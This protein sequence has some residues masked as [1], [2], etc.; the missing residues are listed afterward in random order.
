MAPPYP[1]L[2]SGREIRPISIAEQILIRPG[3]QEETI[4]MKT[5]L[6]LVGLLQ[7]LQ[8]TLAS[9]E[10][11]SDSDGFS[12]HRDASSFWKFLESEDTHL[13]HI[14]A[15]WDNI[16]SGFQQQSRLPE[17]LLPESYNKVTSIT[18]LSK[19]ANL[20]QD[21]ASLFRHTYKKKIAWA[22]AHLKLEKKQGAGGK[23][24]SESFQ[25]Q[26]ELIK[27][28]KKSLL[29]VH[30]VNFSYKRAFKAIDKRKKA[31][32]LGSKLKKKI[33]PNSNIGTFELAFNL[34]LLTSLNY[35]VKR[36]D[37]TGNSLDELKFIRKGTDLGTIAQVFSELINEKSVD[38]CIYARIASKLI[39][40]N[41][42]TRLDNGTFSI[43]ARILELAKTYDESL[44]DRTYS[45]ILEKWLKSPG[46]Q[47]RA[48]N[49]IL[50]KS[51]KHFATDLAQIFE[52]RELG[53]LPDM[54]INCFGPMN[55][56]FRVQGM[57]LDRMPCSDDCQT[58][59]QETIN[60]YL[61]NGKGPSI[62]ST[63]D[64]KALRRFIGKVQYYYKVYLD[65]EKWRTIVQNA[66]DNH[67]FLI[68][69]DIVLTRSWSQTS[70]IQL[71][72]QLNNMMSNGAISSTPLRKEYV[73][74]A[75]HR[76]ASS[77]ALSKLLKWG[78]LSEQILDSFACEELKQWKMQRRSRF[79]KRFLSYLSEDEL[80]YATKDLKES[81]FKLNGDCTTVIDCQQAIRFS[82]RQNIS[83]IER[84]CSPIKIKSQ[85]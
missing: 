14:R 53:T 40:H 70:I 35:H 44:P 7:L 79:S 20:C 34:D 5:L 31:A 21:S 10:L 54:P 17:N 46:A 76:F 63:S 72:E 28:L 16:E 13:T 45:D 64:I 50:R 4:K 41:V 23:Y 77:R 83:I 12:E 56:Y 61:E 22:W 55:C 33:W 67:G 69:A 11:F 62:D 75:C 37:H 26:K 78:K 30:E 38:F 9:S 82:F 73:D 68:L 59:L 71:M 80:K 66:V 39:A 27:E 15:F 43:P 85:I 19:L 81:R 84:S 57:V 42:V 8:V 47:A 1:S 65:K 6:F 48:K 32:V 58:E 49:L 36:C 3:H 18:A 25:D 51:E 24:F 60:R 29:K 2:V 52:F 74:F